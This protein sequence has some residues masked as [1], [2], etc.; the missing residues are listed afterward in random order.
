M[1]R[2]VATTD[3]TS[4]DGASSSATVEPVKALSGVWEDDNGCILKTVVGECGDE[5]MNASMIVANRENSCDRPFSGEWNSSVR[6][7]VVSNTLPVWSG[8]PAA[9]CW[10]VSNG[11]PKGAVFWSSRKSGALPRVGHVLVPLTCWRPSLRSD[12]NMGQQAMSTMSL[13]R[14]LA[15]A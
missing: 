13:G 5:L 7:E 4:T 11:F 10:I 15:D 8:D 9:G 2:A 14:Y 6:L 3:R 12:C 1:D